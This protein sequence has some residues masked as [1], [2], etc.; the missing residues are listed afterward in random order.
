MTIKYKTQISIPKAPEESLEVA[1]LEDVTPLFLTR[2]DFAALESPPGSGLYP[3][4]KNRQVSITDLDDGAQNAIQ[5]Y[6]DYGNL[7]S[8]D[9]MNF[10]GEV[11]AI[12][13]SWVSDR[14]GFVKL[15]GNIYNQQP[16][17]NY[18]AAELRIN[19]KIV[20]NWVSSNSLA[21]ASRL[22]INELY[23]VNI[24]DV[25]TYTSTL[26]SSEVNLQNNLYLFFI[27]LK[28]IELL[29]PVIA[30]DAAN[31]AMVP[32]YV[33]IGPNVMPPVTIDTS[34]TFP[35]YYVTWTADRTGYVVCRTQPLGVSIGWISY[36]IDVDGVQ[37]ERDAYV[38]F[39]AGA[40]L[41]YCRTIPVCKGQT[42]K[43]SAQGENFG[44]PDLFGYF[45]PPKFVTTQAANI[46][47]TNPSYTTAEQLT[48][49]TWI[50]G[51]PIYRKYFSNTITMP[52]G[53]Y[54]NLLFYT[55]SV[56][57]NIIK[58]DYLKLI[59]GFGMSYEDWEICLPGTFNGLLQVMIHNIYKHV[60]YISGSLNSV[61]G[62]AIINGIVY[63]T[64]TN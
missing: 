64:K 34:G 55:G 19:G 56:N 48:G 24:G 3:A 2:E 11:G 7:E 9:L 13:R 49:E 57:D 54:T 39:G 38:E 21:S 58:F 22:A 27:P 14:I 8:T 30:E 26:A 20:S 42:L 31:V 12:T 47:I 61:D 17:T 36:Y 29:A 59:P 35:V 51:K 1:R 52:T 18:Y 32:D 50:D 16:N 4:L 25:L 53:S 41:P 28:F 62:Q 60:A 23:A 46:V 33:N 40:G 15:R 37:I 45:V 6:P 43:F 63:Y 44:T 5:S 10:N